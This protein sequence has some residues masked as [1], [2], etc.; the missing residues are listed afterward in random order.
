LFALNSTNAKVAVPIYK[1]QIVVMK[2]SL[3]KKLMLLADRYREISDSLS[4]PAIIRDQDR[5]RDLSREFSQLEPIVTCFRAYQDN[6]QA[7]ASAQ[8]L[9]KDPEL[10]TMA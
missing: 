7:F 10:K 9:L 1:V 6:Q 8:E 4:D 3:E 5:F 2:A